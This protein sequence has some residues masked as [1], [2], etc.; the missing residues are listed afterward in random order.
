MDINEK[1]AAEIAAQ[2]GL[3]GSNNKVNHDTI[4]KLEGKS[5]AQL[6]TEILKL[7]EQLAANNISPVQQQML[8]KRLM[9]MMDANQKARLQKVI[10]LLK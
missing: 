10:E 7:K 6:A 1:M 4:K 2:L 8:L 9:P 5:D 3:G